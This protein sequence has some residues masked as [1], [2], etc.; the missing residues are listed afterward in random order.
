MQY[1][2]T[3]ALICI[4]GQLMPQDIEFNPAEIK[5]EEGG[6]IFKIKM[7][8]DGGLIFES[9]NVIGRNL[10][11]LFDDSNEKISIGYDPLDNLNIINRA[12]YKHGVFASRQVLGDGGSPFILAS[13]EDDL[14]SSGIHGDGDAVTIWSPGDAPQGAGV[15][16]HLFILDE[17]RWF[18]DANPYNNSAL[19]AYVN[20]AGAWTVSDRNRKSN[21]KRFEKVIPKIQKMNAYSYEYKLS[22]KE[23]EKGQVPIQ[24]VGLMAQEIE[25]IVPEAVNKTTSGEYFINY[26]MVTSI[27][28]EALKEQQELINKLE[29]RITALEDR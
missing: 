11:K 27:L 4:V 18:D 10:L 29:A 17:D 22:E 14:E 8:S 19:E 5:I 21:I 1:F 12:T 23:L 13:R 20:S 2:L 15:V 25:K 3:L 9:D 16:G 24:A 26:N 7:D 6:E 28:V